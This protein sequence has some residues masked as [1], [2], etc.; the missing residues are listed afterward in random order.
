MHFRALRPILVT[1]VGSLVCG[2]CI[3]CGGD[4]GLF[5]LWVMCGIFGLGCW[6]LACAC[7]ATCTCK[8]KFVAYYDILRGGGW[9]R[10]SALVPAGAWSF[11]SAQGAG[12]PC[13]PLAPSFGR[14]WVG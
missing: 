12:A 10:I 3:D 5:G 9:S 14:F 11:F 7:G 2:L 6:A 1:M 8:R 4:G 13:A